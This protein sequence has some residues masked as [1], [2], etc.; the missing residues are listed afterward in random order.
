MLPKTVIVW[1]LGATVGEDG[2]T[3]LI[4]GVPATAV[5]VKEFDCWPFGLFTR[6]VYAPGF[7][8]VMIIWNDVPDT[9]WICAPL[10]VEL[11]PL[12]VTD[13]VRPAWKFAPN[14]LTVWSF[15]PAVGAAG[16]IEPMLG[17][18]DAAATAVNVN[19][20]DCCP[21]GLFTRT[22]YAPGFASVMIIWNEVPDTFWI[23]A[24]LSI[25]LPPIHVTETVRP[26]W[27]F[28]PD[29]VTV[30]SFGPA[31]GVAGETEPMLGGCIAAGIALN[32]NGVDC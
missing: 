19:E 25:A 7:A 30:W 18:C 8:S 13:T 15:G 22:V 9:F 12:H 5:K 21:F 26:D 16:E 32:V 17:G 4:R 27:K 11:P 23:W 28:A 3:E 31:V 29:T 24:P 14:T 10:S 1:L 20:F 6:I 2:E